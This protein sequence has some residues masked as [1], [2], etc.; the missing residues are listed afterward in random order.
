M[1]SIFIKILK[2]IPRETYQGLRE[3]GRQALGIVIDR[4]I[5]NIKEKINKK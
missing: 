2:A 5:D 1:K 3:L 4:K